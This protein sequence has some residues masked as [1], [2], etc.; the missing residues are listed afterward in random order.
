[1]ISN[2]SKFNE[3]VKNRLNILKANFILYQIIYINMILWK[4]WWKAQSWPEAY[5][6]R[7]SQRRIF[8]TGIPWWVSH[9]EQKLIRVSFRRTWIFSGVRVTQSVVFCVVLCK[10]LFVFLPFPLQIVLD[11]LLRFRASD[12]T[13]SIFKPFS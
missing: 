5:L 7:V 9:V 10:S 8:V 3:P 2:F 11:D 13:C 6:F 4:Y 12:Y 1:M